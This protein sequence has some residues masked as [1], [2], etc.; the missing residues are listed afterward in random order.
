MSNV[1]H[2]LT[3]RPIDPD[4]ERAPGARECVACY[5]HRMVESD[6]CSDELRWV[7]H[8]RRLRARRATALRA[9]LERRGGMCDCDVVSLVWV[10]V[11]GPADWDGEDGPLDDSALLPECPG[12]RTNSTQPCELWSQ[13]ANLPR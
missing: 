10:P 6:G 5:V 2:I 7:E 1:I 11:A 13:A 12:V 9:R 4:G 8:W 3:R